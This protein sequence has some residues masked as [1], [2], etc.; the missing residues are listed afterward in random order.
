MASIALL[1][2]ILAVAVVAGYALR[3]QRL[4]SLDA[5]RADAEHWYD[6]LGGQVLGLPA[7][8]PNAAVRQ[9]LADASERYTAAGAQKASARTAA[10]YRGVREV[11]LEGLHF[12]RAAR[13]A[14]GLD[15]GPELPTTAAQIAAGQLRDTQRFFTGDGQSIEGQPH[16]A[17][18]N[19]FYYPG[20]VV[21]GRAMPGGWYSQP[22]WKGAL[23]GGAAALGGSLLLGGLADAVSGGFETAEGWGRGEG[24]GGGGDWGGGD[25]GGGD[26]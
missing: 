1:L 20:G 3:R 11:S 15:P 6:R 9:A 14:L 24:W 5:A 12:I 10:A 13:V 23:I 7:A 21:G 18:T 8:S 17:A 2:L 22:F 26:W 4:A 25:W 19:P 16:A